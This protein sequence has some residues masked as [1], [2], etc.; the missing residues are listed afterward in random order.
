MK[1]T[2]KIFITVVG[3]MATI[4][5]FFLVVL[6]LE[7]DSTEGSV[8]S[9]YAPLDA[10]CSENSGYIKTTSP[11]YYTCASSSNTIGMTKCIE[12]KIK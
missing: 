10:V 8:I 2:D 6:L 3:M 12:E 7:S 4:I 9:C 11:V 5:I 1:T